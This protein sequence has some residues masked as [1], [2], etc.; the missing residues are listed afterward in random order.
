[1]EWDCSGCS[2]EK[3]VFTVPQLLFYIVHIYTY[4]YI[5][6][7]ICICIKSVYIYIHMFT[8]AQYRTSLAA[9][10]FLKDVLNDCLSL[11]FQSTW[12]ELG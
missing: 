5:Y 8:Y 4:I 12:D 1:M 10:F 6:I 9:F 2:N 3:N 7:C 11:Y